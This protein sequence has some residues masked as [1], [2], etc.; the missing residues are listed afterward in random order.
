MGLDK[1]ALRAALM[2]TR[3]RSPESLAELRVPALCLTGDEDAVI[4]PESVAAVARHIPG[5]R[6]V[7]VPACG[8]SVYWE[9]PATFN[10]AVMDFLHDVGATGATSVRAR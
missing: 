5:A 3:T 9:Q 6:L 7:R 10:R 2:A 8:H 4:P 1:A